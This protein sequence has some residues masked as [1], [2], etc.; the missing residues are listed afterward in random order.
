[1][2]PTC[3][4]IEWAIGFDMAMMVGIQTVEN[5]TVSFGYS[6]SAKLGFVIASL[7]LGGLIMVPL[8]PIVGDRWGRRVSIILGSLVMV[9]GAIIQTAAQNCEYFYNIFPSC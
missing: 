9:V 1:M 6:S 7:T 2:I 4:G 3:M 5:W 8:I